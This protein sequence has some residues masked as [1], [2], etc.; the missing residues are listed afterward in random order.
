M[1]RTVELYLEVVSKGTNWEENS[2]Y[3]TGISK[4]SSMAES[5]GAGEGGGRVEAEEV[6]DLGLHQEER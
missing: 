3:W 2:R 1:E 6:Q 5:S 4:E